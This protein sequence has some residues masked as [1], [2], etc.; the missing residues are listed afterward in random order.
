MEEEKKE[1]IEVQKVEKIENEDTEKI[2][3]TKQTTEKSKKDRKGFCIASM[4]LG[5]VAMVFFCLWYISIPCGILALIFGILGVKSTNKGM[6]IAG[7][8]TGAI[9]LLISFLI[10]VIFFIYGLAMGISDNL[11]NDYD[12]N[13]YRNFNHHDWDWYDYD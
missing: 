12:S 4:V 1:M 8:V 2:L 7:I 11:I 3:E 6:A 5:I 10:I 9:G 13:N